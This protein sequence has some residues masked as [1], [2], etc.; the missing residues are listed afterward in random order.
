MKRVVERL[1][2]FSLKR[3]MSPSQGRQAVRSEDSST[4]RQLSSGG[5]NYI[6][7]FSL[8]MLFYKNG[9]FHDSLTGMSIDY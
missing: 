6:I 7:I 1:L 9:G 4:I 3:G 5:N 8:V 2:C